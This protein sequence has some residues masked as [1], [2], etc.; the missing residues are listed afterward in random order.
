MR[1]DPESVAHGFYRAMMVDDQAAQL[2]Y[3]ADDATFH[4]HIPDGIIGYSGVTCGK[5]QLAE[6]LTYI[7]AHWDVVEIEPVYMQADGKAVNAQM[8]F[9]FR[10]KRSG[11]LLDGGIRHVFR[12]A[13]GRIVRL[14][15]YMDA[16]LLQAFLTMAAAHS[17]QPA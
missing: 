6:R 2:A 17:P 11:D 9:V 7:Y 14:D 8:R 3:F 10:F 1:S 15:E 12:I 5:P 16:A 4:Q 13:G